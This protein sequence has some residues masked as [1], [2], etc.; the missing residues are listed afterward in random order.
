MSGETQNPNEKDLGIIP[1]RD[2]SRADQVDKQLEQ[3]EK[4]P[5]SSPYDALPAGVKVKFDNYAKL[6][7]EQWEKMQG[8]LR[9]KKKADKA[10]NKE[11]S[12][13]AEKKWL[14]TKNTW[15]E[16]IKLIDT[17]NAIDTELTKLKQN[18][19]VHKAEIEKLES[20]IEELG[21]KAD[22]VLERELAKKKTSVEI[23]DAEAAVVTDMLVEI[24]E[25]DIMAEKNIPEHPD[26]TKNWEDFYDELSDDLIDLAGDVVEKVTTPERI[27][28]D[29]TQGFVGNFDYKHLF[30]E[31]ILP[32]LMLRLN[33]LSSNMDGAHY[34]KAVSGVADAI[35]KK[36][37]AHVELKRK[38]IMD[39]KNHPGRIAKFFGAG[40]P[41][42]T[43]DDIEELK[44][45]HQFYEE[46]AKFLNS[47]VPDVY[48]AK[49]PAKPKLK[50]VPPPPPLQPKTKPRLELVPPLPQTT[51]GKSIRPPSGKTMGKLGAAAALA[52]VALF[53]GE[54]GTSDEQ[55]AETGGSEVAVTAP[56]TAGAGELPSK[57]VDL[58]EV[59]D[60]ATPVKGFSAIDVSDI[61]K[62]GLTEEDKTVIDDGSGSR[63][64]SRVSRGG[65]KQ[66]GVVIMGDEP[67]DSYAQSRPLDAGL[68]TG[69][70][71]LVHATT[72]RRDIRT[73][74]DYG[75]EFKPGR[76]AE[77]Q[78]LDIHLDPDRTKGE[79]SV[80][81]GSDHSDDDAR[82]NVLLKQ[83]GGA[84]RRNIHGDALTPRSIFDRVGELMRQ[85]DTARKR[86]NSVAAD[87]LYRD[88]RLLKG[89]A[90]L[91]IGESR[92]KGTDTGNM[93]DSFDGDGSHHGDDGKIAK[94]PKKPK[95]TK[96]AQQGGG[97]TLKSGEGPLV[98]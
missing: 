97:S 23:I 22:D 81:V 86:G 45:V 85:G 71:A 63:V 84:D 18:R 29:K 17:V 5:E 12:E 52:G 2:V 15:K 87:S 31:N 21:T 90:S 96:P 37:D 19:Q 54:R 14:E 58:G 98:F 73:I 57:S 34:A 49:T 3:V 38:E 13:R 68:G 9:V 43:K 4:I 33:N 40:E 11:E 83:I 78:G 48:K 82:L 47:Y 59:V 39:G 77:P 50:L 91:M 32:N 24:G 60:N 75:P 42:L 65:K 51:G 56:A 26:V 76:S 30:T 16:T 55:K 1:N 46:I 53:G 8:F 36:A 94:S 66:K 89:K 10:G 6:A 92:V 74:P 70:E 61:A 95:I 62:P 64:L 35:L 28:S 27:K 69:R 41:K 80:E 25:E 20:H 72:F 79:F 93:S 88:A 44:T 7:N 67:A